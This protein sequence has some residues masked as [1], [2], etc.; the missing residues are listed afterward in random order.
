MKFDLN[1]EVQTQ[2]NYVYSSEYHVQLSIM[3]KYF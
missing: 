3:L 2:K 1:F